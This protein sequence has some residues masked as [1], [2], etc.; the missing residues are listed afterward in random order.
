MEG[1]TDVGRCFDEDET[2]E[3]LLGEGG[4][5]DG[6]DE[7]VVVVVA[8]ALLALA[9]GVGLEDDG[10]DE[11]Q[12]GDE[13]AETLV[14]SRVLLGR[15]LRVIVLTNGITECDPCFADGPVGDGVLDGV[16]FLLLIPGHGHMEV[17]LLEEF[18]DAGLD[19]ILGLLVFQLGGEDEA[20]GGDVVLD[21]IEGT[22]VPGVGDAESNVV[23]SLG[24]GFVVV[25]VRIP[26]WVRVVPVPVRVPL[27]VE[28][29][30]MAG[31]RNPIVGGGEQ[32]LSLVGFGI[33]LIHGFLLGVVELLLST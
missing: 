24:A 6:L 32:V 22:E 2:V 8:D 3:D 21:P 13:T 28:S 33:G 1:E 25:V 23:R 18:L 11:F 5:V 15:D 16:V 17:V 26:S 14:V 20:D 29:C 12:G 27:G 7:E 10:S 30:F 31:L 9:D 19:E 4:D